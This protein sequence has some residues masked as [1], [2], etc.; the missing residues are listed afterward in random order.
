MLGMTLQ[1]GKSDLDEVRSVLDREPQV[2]DR[3]IVNSDG[4]KQ[5]SEPFVQGIREGL[6]RAGRTWG[7]VFYG[8]ARKF[9]GMT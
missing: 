5:L 6:P 2:E 1:Q 3:L 4:A 8:N 9:W 7:K